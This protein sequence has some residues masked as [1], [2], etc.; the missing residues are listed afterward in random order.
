MKTCRGAGSY[1]LRGCDGGIWFGLH[2]LMMGVF[3]KSKV[4]APP[5]LSK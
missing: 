4:K 5:G 3:L 2:V 1:R